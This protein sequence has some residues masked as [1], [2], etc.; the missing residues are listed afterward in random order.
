MK[1]YVLRRFFEGES[2]PAELEADYPGTVSQESDVGGT[3]VRRFHFEPMS[4]DFDVT[5][6]HILKLVDAMS[7]GSLRPETLKAVCFCLEATDHFLWDADTPD[8]ERVA[9]AIFWIGTPEINY[10]LTPG[11]LSKIRHYLL[12]G[13]KQ[14]S[15][16]DT[17]VRRAGA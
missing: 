9:D 13:E 16:A 10:P 11:V 4:V 2:G 1:E 6:S 5:S 8:G 17:K 3:P 7:A 15:T 14:L 12:T